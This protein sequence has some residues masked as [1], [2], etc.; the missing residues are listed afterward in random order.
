MSF[1]LA[2]WH[3][4]G[5]TTPESAA[6][7]YDQLT[8][9]EVGVVEPGPQIAHFYDDV[10]AALPDLTE[11]NMEDSPWASPVYRTPEC[12]IVAISWS[13]SEPVSQFLLA[14]AGKHGL[15]TYDP[16]DRVVHPP[17]SGS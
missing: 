11:D 12:V 15:T 2:F 9:G 8:D 10:V 7:I 16:Q 13:Q 5:P 3:E 6:Q 14:L 4:N 17:T 1:D